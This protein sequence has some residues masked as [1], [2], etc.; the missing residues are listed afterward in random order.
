MAKYPEISDVPEIQREYVR[1]RRKGE[2]HNVAEMLATQAGPSLM[3]DARFLM[4]KTEG[5]VYMSGLARYPGDP[6]ARV[7]SRHDVKKICR[8]RNWSC[9]GSVKVK[10]VEHEV[11]PGPAVAPDIVEREVNQI[12]ALEPEKAGKRQ[13]LREEVTEQIKPHWKK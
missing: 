11:A 9:E 13:E 2:S 12:I 3:T 6:K 7:S 10:S 1:M 5:S 4:G 8:K